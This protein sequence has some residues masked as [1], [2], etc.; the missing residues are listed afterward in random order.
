[1]D[2][3]FHE[4]RM[5]EKRA[6]EQIAELEKQIAL[7]A[8]GPLINKLK[9][10]YK[11]FPK[12]V[13]YLE[14][15]LKD[16]TKNHEIFKPAGSAPSQMPFFAPQEEADSFGKYK[17][18]LFINNEKRKGAPVVIEPS[19]SYY[20]LFGKIEYKSQMMA[21]STDFTMVKSGAIHEANGGYLILQAKDVLTEPFAWDTL[22]KV[23]MYRQAVIEN[24]GG[25]YNFVPTVTL[26]PEPIPLNVKVILIG[27]PLYYFM[28]ATDEDFQ[29]LFKV[30]VDFD[31]EMPRTPENLRQ[32]VSFVKSVCQRGNMKHFN[33]AGL[34]KIIEYGSRLAGQQNKLSTRF[35]EVTEIVYE[36]N[37]IAQAERSEYVDAAHVDKAIK[38][39]KYRSNQMEE[40]IQEQILQEKI[41]LIPKVL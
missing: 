24:M 39:R 2:E 20:N 15:V 3:I 40:K 34:A 35:N 32:Y 33:K 38:E 28:Y 1:M 37:A 17:V 30:K 14:S 21:L 27:S 4:G 36:A 22:K 16:V 10:E 25:Q 41:L 18:N 8:A 31:I 12:L 11:E 13:E 23:L 9:E 26:R 7:F 5:L 29:K 19:P 6:K